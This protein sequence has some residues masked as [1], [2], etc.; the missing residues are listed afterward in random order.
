MCG[1]GEANPLAVTKR[2]IFERVDCALEA[3]EKMSNYADL[4][5]FT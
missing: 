4:Y 2:L 1:V 5:L 3:L